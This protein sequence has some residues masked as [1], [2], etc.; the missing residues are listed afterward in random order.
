MQYSKCDCTKNSYKGITIS[1]D[2]DHNSSWAYTNIEAV[3]YSIWVLKDTVHQGQEHKEMCVDG[4]RTDR[5]H[6]F[7]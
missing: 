2:I 5:K 6:V 1:L 3:I 7:E 4:L